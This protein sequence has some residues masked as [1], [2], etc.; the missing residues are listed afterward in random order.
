MGRQWFYSLI[1]I[2]NILEEEMLK[3]VN[4]SRSFK[5]IPL[6]F[7]L[8]FISLIMEFRNL[9]SFEEY[10]PIYL[11]S[12]NYKILLTALQEGLNVFFQISFQVNV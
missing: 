5:R 10:K 9:V 2:L 4:E 1:T 7:N 8:S 12:C 6:P 3:V 11:C